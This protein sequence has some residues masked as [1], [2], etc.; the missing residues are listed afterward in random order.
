MGGAQ[1]CW[2]CDR[3]TG[4][5]S[6]SRRFI[7]VKGWTAKPTIIR[8]DSETYGTVIKSYHI[9]KCPLFKADKKRRITCA[10]LGKALGVS[11]KTVHCWDEQTL[12]DKAEQKGLHIT[13]ERVKENRAFYITK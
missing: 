2:E 7:P 12:I 1:L 9:T 8:D 3:A 10:E 11:S 6:W 5:C 4:G 13:I